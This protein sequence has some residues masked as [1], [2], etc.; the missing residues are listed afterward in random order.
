MKK[1]YY[2]TA[3]FNGMIITDGGRFVNVDCFPQDGT[4]EDAKTFDF[5]GIENCDTIEGIANELSAEV[6]SM[7]DIDVDEYD[8]FEEIGKGQ[9][10]YL[11]EYTVLDEEQ[12]AGSKPY[13]DCSN[14]G[15]KITAAESPEQAI[16]FVIDY[17]FEQ[18]CDNEMFYD[19]EIE[20]TEDSI[21]I[22]NEER[23][24]IYYYYNFKAEIYLSS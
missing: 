23:I 4:I 19:C 8:V 21:S 3:D 6:L 9:I 16:E 5:S 18:L 20:K 24:K 2:E 12:I 14:I 7:A 10:D 1:Y 13:P 22:I 11:V 15:D 17:I